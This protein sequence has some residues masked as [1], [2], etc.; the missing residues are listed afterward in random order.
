MSE[1]P[2]AERREHSFTHHGITIEDPYAWLRDESFPTVDDQDVLAYLN[3]ENDYFESFMEPLAAGK[4]ALTEELIGRLEKNDWSVPVTDGEWTYQTRYH[5]DDD[6]PVHVRW[7]KGIEDPTDQDL[8]VLIDERKLSEGLEYFRLGRRAISHDGHLLAYAVDTNGSERYQIRIKDLRTGEL[9]PDTIEDARTS[10]VWA[11]DNQRFFYLLSDENWRPYQVKQHTL[12]EDSNA[13]VVLYEEHDPA[14]FLGIEYSTSLRY[15]IMESGGHDASEVRFM[16][17]GGSS[18]DLTLV[19]E[20]SDEHEYHI[21]HQSGRFV[22]HSDL[23]HKNFEVFTAP[24][25]APGIENWEV[26]IDGDENRYIR[27]SSSYENYIVV[28]ALEQGLQ[29]IFLVDREGARTYIEFPEPVY[30]AWVGDNREVHLTHLRISYSSMVTPSTVYDYAVSTKELIH[31]KTTQIPSGYDASLYKSERLMVKARDGVEVPVS[32]VYRSDLRNPAGN[33][34]YLYG[35]GAYGAG[36][37]PSFGSTRIS[38]LDRGFIYAIA[39][40]RGGDELGDA[41]KEGGKLDKRTNTFHDFE[42]VARHLVEA[43]YSNEGQIACVGGSAGGGLMGAVANNA[44][45]LWGAVV[46]HVPFVDILNT[47]LDDTLPLTP[48]EFGEWGNPIE[49]EVVFK[50]LHSYSPYD[51]LEAKDYPPIMVTAG[52]NDPRVTYWEPAKYVAKLRYLKTNDDPVLL[53]T[54]MVAGHGG[55]T[56]RTKEM[57]ERA[58]EY[59][60][61]FKVMDIPFDLPD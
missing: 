21:D 13:D 8:Q 19:A 6:Y 4:D 10:I 26:L 39:H 20:R 25:D 36:M 23:N 34:M 27:G 18:E 43:K 3:A 32:L 60:F 42:D 9:L 59:A 45:E 17:L 12:G 33:P 41:W 2:K 49:D 31:R 51:Q 29:Q 46:A 35:Y 16:P 38:L 52:L 47:M 50:Y 37:T 55:K 7:M 56:G 57:E 48:I 24:E 30:A 14:F 28:S 44:P 5:G 61:I 40:I 15:L 58:E 22:I 54:E 53:R 11:S 1:P